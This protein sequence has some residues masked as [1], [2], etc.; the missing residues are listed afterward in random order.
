M[1][2]FFSVLALYISF[3]LSEENNINLHFEDGFCNLTNN[4]LTGIKES[5]V[6]LI[7]ALIFNG[8]IIVG[9]LKIIFNASEDFQVVSDYEME[10]LTYQQLYIFKSSLLDTL[11]YQV[12]LQSGL[13]KAIEY[14][15]PIDHEEINANRDIIII[16]SIINLLRFSRVFRIIERPYT[17]PFFYLSSAAL[18]DTYSKYGLVSVFSSRL[19]V[20]ILV[21][22]LCFFLEHL[23]LRPASS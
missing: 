5:W 3:A 20:N 2:I 10:N 18:A 1:K 7:S 15:F 12:L 23:T 4:T 6:T 17:L 8:D 14:F 22:N 16:V 21:L 9:G 19:F 13:M 11:F